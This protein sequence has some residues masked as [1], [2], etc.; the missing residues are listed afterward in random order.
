MLKQR[1]GLFYFYEYVYYSEEYD[2][3][4]KISTKNYDSFVKAKAIQRLER[5]QNLNKMF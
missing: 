3:K 5:G 2:I 1:A 4:S